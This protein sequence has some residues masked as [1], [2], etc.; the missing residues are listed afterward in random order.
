MLDKTKLL[1]QK[2][3]F[4]LSETKKG[5]IF[6]KNAPKYELVISCVTIKNKGLTKQLIRHF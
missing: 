5:P 1:K 6:E 3:H 4:K 2:L